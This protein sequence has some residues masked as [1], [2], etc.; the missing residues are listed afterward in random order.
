MKKIL[1]ASR[2]PLD[3]MAKEVLAHRYDVIMLTQREVLWPVG[4]S[5]CLE[6][7][8]ELFA[9]FDVVCGVFPAQAIEM[10]VN[11]FFGKAVAFSPVSTPVHEPKTG[12]VR[13]F[14]FVRWAC[15]A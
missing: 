10:L 6:V 7:A 9:K 2:H 5:D 15:I 1:W 4:Y 14:E 12:K 3:P 11:E 8:R 13:R